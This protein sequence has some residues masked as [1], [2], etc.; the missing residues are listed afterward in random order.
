MFGIPIPKVNLY[1]I[2]LFSFS[3][4]VFGLAVNFLL[5]ANYGYIY[6]SESVKQALVH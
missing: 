6:S 2:K 4:I 5:L 3:F 1:M